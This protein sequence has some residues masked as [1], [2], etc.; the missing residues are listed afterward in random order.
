MEYLSG[1]KENTNSKD[2]IIIRRMLKRKHLRLETKNTRS[3]GT[4]TSQQLTLKKQDG[5]EFLFPLAKTFRNENT[6]LK[7]YSTR[8]MEM[9]AI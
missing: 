5:S 3:C 2:D 1:N 9:V 4:P 6:S 7:C 8:G